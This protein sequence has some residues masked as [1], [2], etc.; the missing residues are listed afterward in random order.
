MWM[1]MCIQRHTQIYIGTNACML[2]H[3][4]KLYTH[5]HTYTW[6]HVHTCIQMH[7][8][9]TYVSFCYCHNSTVSVI[10]QLLLVVTPLI[11]TTSRRCYMTAPCSANDLSQWQHHQMG[12]WRCYQ[13]SYFPWYVLKTSLT[14]C[15]TVDGVSRCY[16]SV[17]N[18]VV[19]A[20]YC[21]GGVL[22]W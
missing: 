15:A 16:R 6:T 3:T 10:C 20:N 11:V 2:I 7:T 18:L 13:H 9:T 17:F 19:Y 1:H 12:H 21:Q 4:H 8:H 22:S 14:N 5:I